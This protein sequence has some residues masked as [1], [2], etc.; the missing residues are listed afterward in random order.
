M[1]LARILTLARIACGLAGAVALAGVDPEAL[2]GCR[3]LG[4]CRGGGQATHGKRDRRK[5]E[6][7]A[8]R[9]ICLHANNLLMNSLAERARR[10]PRTE[11]T[12]RY[13][14]QEGTKL[15]KFPDWKEISGLK[16][17]HSDAEAGDERQK[18]VGRQYLGEVRE[19]RKG[20]S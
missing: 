19:H 9:G 2:D 12:N 20:L 15:Q 11:L 4:G 6:G 5:G 16:E 17:D 14:L 8:G 3:L 1:A 7:R 18:L 13:S 10:E